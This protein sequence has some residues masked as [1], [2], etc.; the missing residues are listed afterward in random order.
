MDGRGSALRQDSLSYFLFKLFQFIKHLLKLVFQLVFISS[1]DLFSLLLQYRFVHAH[2]HSLCI[3]SCPGYCFSLSRRFKWSLLRCWLS[4]LLIIECFHH[5]IQPQ[6]SY[7]HVSWSKAKNKLILGQKRK[8]HA[9][10]V[11]VQGGKVRGSGAVLTKKAQNG[12]DHQK[13]QRT[14]KNWV[15]FI[16]LTCEMFVFRNIK[17]S[18][19]T[20]FSS[21]CNPL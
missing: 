14:H 2:D 21:P 10:V 5:Q 13:S 15:R 20:I 4:S 11:R 3:Y 17:P 19:S 12:R 1:F 6:A 7:A 18:K 8:R 16:N 9:R